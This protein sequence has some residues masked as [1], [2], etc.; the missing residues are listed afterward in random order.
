MVHSDDPLAPGEVRDCFTDVAE[1]PIQHSRDALIVEQNIVGTEI[2]VPHDAATSRRGIKRPS[3]KVMQA[4]EDSTTCRQDNSGLACGQ[5][6]LPML[7]LDK[8][9]LE[10]TSPLIDD[11]RYRENFCQ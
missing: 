5:Q 4:P 6:V 7:T 9:R 8:F 3:I 2:A 1:L 10:F 11:V